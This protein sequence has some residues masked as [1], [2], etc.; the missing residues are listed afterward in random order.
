M[1]LIALQFP[2]GGI[3]LLAAPARGVADAY[4]IKEGDRCEVTR[5]KGTQ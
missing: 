4:R 1:H 5:I 3:A 2:G